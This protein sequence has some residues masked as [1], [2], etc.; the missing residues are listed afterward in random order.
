MSHSLT[1]VWIRAVFG[2]KNLQPLIVT[3]LKE[4]LHNHI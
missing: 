1:K 3:Q 4:N 2:T